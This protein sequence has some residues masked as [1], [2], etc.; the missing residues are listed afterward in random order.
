MAEAIM[1]VT[2]VAV[3]IL[4]SRNWT[5]ISKKLLK[6]TK[7]VTLNKLFPLPIS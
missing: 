5:K 7:S 6:N 3:K 2:T 1:T 4:L